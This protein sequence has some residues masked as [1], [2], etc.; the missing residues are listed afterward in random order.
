MTTMA[1]LGVVDLPPWPGP[2]AV[3]RDYV[4][5]WEAFADA[6]ADGLDKVV[7]PGDVVPPSLS[8]NP[9]RRIA[10]IMGFAEHQ[11][12]LGTWERALWGGGP[13]DVATV[14]AVVQRAVGDL[15]AAYLGGR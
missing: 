13:T 5:G 1:E 2:T 14:H 9:A 8:A 11:V 4:A 7:D 6:V 10:W 3:R 15:R 12:A